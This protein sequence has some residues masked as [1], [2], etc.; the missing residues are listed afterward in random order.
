MEQS[1]TWILSDQGPRIETQEQW[2]IIDPAPEPWPDQ[3]AAP[4]IMIVFPWD[5]PS[6]EKRVSTSMCEH[7]KILIKLTKKELKKM[8]S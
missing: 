6:I 5:F 4:I 1:Q 2:N 3:F 8:I 7:D